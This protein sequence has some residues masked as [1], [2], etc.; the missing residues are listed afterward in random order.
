[1][2]WGARRAAA[3]G[4]GCGRS[5]FAIGLQA[6]SRRGLSFVRA[7]LFLGASLGLL[8]GTSESLPLEDTWTEVKILNDINGKVV[9]G[10]EISLVVSLQQHF[11]PLNLYICRVASSPGTFSHVI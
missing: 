1:M 11:P 10:G 8:A 2:L 9:Q 6:F 4:L 3:R 7:L 5:V